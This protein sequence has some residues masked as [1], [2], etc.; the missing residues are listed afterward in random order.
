MASDLDMFTNEIQK[1]SYKAEKQDRFEQKVLLQLLRGL[2]CRPGLATRTKY[3][4]EGEFGMIWLMKNY[5]DFPVRLM[6]YKSSTTMSLPTLVKW[7]ERTMAYKELQKAR[8]NY[9]EDGVGIIFASDGDELPE[10]ILHDMCEWK[11][12]PEGA[13]RVEIKNGLIIEP[14]TGFIQSVIFNDGW[15]LEE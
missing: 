7:P 14:L 3:R 5:P 9:N 12:A 4:L 2:E 6:T 10:M 11:I 1:K 8:E 15:T 13:W